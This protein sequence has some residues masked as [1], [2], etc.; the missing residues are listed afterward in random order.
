MPRFRHEWKHEISPS[1]RMALR[2]RLGAVCRVDGHAADGRY[3]LRSLYF[4]TLA[5]VRG[6]R[7]LD[8]RK[9]SAP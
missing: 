7:R 9:V 3:F 5:E 1:D 4:E 8:R 6:K 2:A